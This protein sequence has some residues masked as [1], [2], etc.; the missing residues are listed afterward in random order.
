MSY[1]ILRIKKLQKMG[2]ICA[3]FDHNFRERDTPNA[4]PE[5]T[6]NNQSIGAQNSQEATE[7]LKERLATV[8]KIRKNAVQC[9]EYFIGASPEFFKDKGADIKGYFKGAVDWLRERHGAENVVS[10]TLHQDE[11]SPHL[12]AYVVPIDPKGKLNAS[13]FFDGRTKLKEMQT[14]F[15]EQVGRKVGLERGIE[16]SKARHTTIMEYYAK[17]ND[18]E[19]TVGAVKADL[20]KQMQEVKNMSLQK[21]VEIVKKEQERRAKNQGQDR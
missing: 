18:F 15:V 5:R 10:V 4:D 13:H 3:S 11:T 2:N 14:E 9:V 20:A 7:K 21:A 16:G 1:A 19:R 17:A 8:P 6:P 12:C